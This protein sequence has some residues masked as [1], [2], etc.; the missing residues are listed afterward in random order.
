MIKFYNS[1]KILAIEINGHFKSSVCNMISSLTQFSQ[2][3]C[4]KMF[5]SFD[6]AKTFILA[7]RRSEKLYVKKLIA[8]LTSFFNQNN[9]QF[10][11]IQIKKLFFKLKKDKLEFV[12]KET[13]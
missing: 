8:F 1:K 3:V 11:C 4:P 7:K 10:E 6:E 9:I 2:W 12:I 13:N 5:V